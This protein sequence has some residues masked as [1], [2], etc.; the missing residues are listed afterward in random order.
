MLVTI[1]DNFIITKQVWVLGILLLNSSIMTHFFY[2]GI[3]LCIINL[4]LLSWSQI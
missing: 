4:E 3:I 1:N 2:G